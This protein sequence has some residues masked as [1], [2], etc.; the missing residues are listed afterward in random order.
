MIPAQPAQRGR[1]LQV[2]RGLLQDPA[3]TEAEG[4]RLPPRARDLP[5]QLLPRLHRR[6]EPRQQRRRLRRLAPV[7]QRR[8]LRDQLQEQA[9]LR[10]EAQARPHSKRG[11]RSCPPDAA[12]V[13][14]R[15]GSRDGHLAEREEVRL[16]RH[17]RELEAA[18]PDPGGDR[19][20]ARM[21]V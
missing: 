4:L 13:R 16:Q 6:D 12:A 5:G 9:V 20:Q 19:L 21:R 11:R 7:R 14:R 2:Q 8:L 15:P 18:E 17:R 10:R 3:E 1:H